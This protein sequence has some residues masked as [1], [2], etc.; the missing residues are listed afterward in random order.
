MPIFTLGRTIHKIQYNLSVF[1]FG[2]SICF[3]HII[4]LPFVDVFFDWHSIVSFFRE[5]LFP[6][7]VVTL[8][9]ICNVIRLSTRKILLQHRLEIRSTPLQMEQESHWQ[10]FS[11]NNNHT[12][13]S[14]LWMHFY[15]MD[16]PR[17]S[18]SIHT[19]YLDYSPSEC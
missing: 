11:T 17:N 3:V 14:A 5:S 10:C 19:F 12:F 4:V 9:F 8:R 1:I 16:T 13:D 6:F 2:H 7:Y 15:F 18:S